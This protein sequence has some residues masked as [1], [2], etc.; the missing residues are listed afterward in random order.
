VETRPNLFDGPGG[1]AD[2]LVA[3]VA[4]ARVGEAAAARSR[5]GFLRRTAGEDATFAG[6]LVDLAERGA[7][8]LVATTA[9]RRHRGVIQAVGADFCALRTAE[10]RDIVLAHRGI[11]SVRP[12]GRLGTTGDR[13]V[14]VPVGL[15]E[16]LAV[17]AENRPRVLV[18]PLGAGVDSGDRGLAGELRSVGR[19]VVV[20]HLDGADQRTAYVAL[21]SVAE[22][23]AG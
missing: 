11:A 9:G 5:E 2:R 14:E 10:G 20:L 13:V 6:V 1:L 12:D 4:A 8:V 15:A 21:N 22:V 18:V 19:D 17:L 7:P 16:A 23:S 3:W